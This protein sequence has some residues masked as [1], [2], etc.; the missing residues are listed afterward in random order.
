[1]TTSSRERDLASSRVILL[2]TRT[3]RWPVNVIRPQLSAGRP[4]RPCYERVFT[5]SHLG[6]AARRGSTKRRRWALQAIT[7]TARRRSADGKHAKSPCRPR[8]TAGI[9]LSGRARRDVRGQRM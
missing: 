6:G 4:R 9:R 1:M 3:V 2:V 5:R 8:L 7:G